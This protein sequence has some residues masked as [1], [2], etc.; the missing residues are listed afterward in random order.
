MLSSSTKRWR[1]AVPFANNSA[2]LDNL[3]TGFT[4]VETY[5]LKV[6]RSIV[7]ILPCIIRAPPTAITMSDNVHIKN[8]IIALKRPIA[9]WNC[10]LDVLY[11]SLDVLNFCCSI[12]SFA[13][14]LAVFIPVSP[15]SISVLMTA[16]FCLTRI[17]ASLI[18]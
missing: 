5:K 11:V 2:K 15:D 14:A 1:P 16:T 6:I 12:V 17:E 10:F 7:S 13:K 3:R 9:L 8:S 18:E 4:N